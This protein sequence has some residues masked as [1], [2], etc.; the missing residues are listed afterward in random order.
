LQPTFAVLSLAGSLRAVQDWKDG[1]LAKSTGCS[2]RGPGSN[3]Q[4]PHGNQHLS[5]TPVPRLLTSSHRHTYGQDTNEHEINYL[6]GGFALFPE[7]LLPAH[8]FPGIV[9]I[10]E[11]CTAFLLLR[12]L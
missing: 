7:P 10:L 6:R 1:S 4:H 5:V 12:G 9:K 3:S 11:H 2:S 8:P